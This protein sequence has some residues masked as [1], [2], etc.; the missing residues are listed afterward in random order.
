M[1][2][3]TGLLS[4]IVA[5]GDSIRARFGG[6]AGNWPSKSKLNAFITLFTYRGSSSNSQVAEQATGRQS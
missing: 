5:L 1:S 6:I 2:F 4:D 3:I